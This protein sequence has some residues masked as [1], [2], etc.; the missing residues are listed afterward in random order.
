MK[1]MTQMEAYQAVRKPALPQNRIERP[2]KGA[3]YSRKNKWG[4]RYDD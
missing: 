3:G 2:K 1:L 4:K